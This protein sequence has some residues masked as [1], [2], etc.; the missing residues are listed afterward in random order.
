MSDLIHTADE[1]VQ[2]A[3]DAISAAHHL[4]AF[5]GAG[6]SAESGI[7]TFRG[8]SGIW[9][10]YDPLVLD[11]GF[12]KQNPA[13]SWRAIRD[14][15]YKKAAE[16]PPNAGHL[17]LADW[18]KRGVLK[19][20]ITQN[21]DDLHYQAGNRSVSE[22]HGNIRN[23]VCMKT[24]KL[25]PFDPSVFQD[26][27]PVPRS[28]WGGIYKPDFVF[29][30]EGIPADAA[31][32]SAQETSQCDVML[33]IGSTGAVYPAAQLPQLAASNGATIIEINP[34][35]SAYTNTITDI[36]LQYKAAEILPLINKL[37]RIQE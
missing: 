18:E 6:M 16:N 2:K 1:T 23:L 10:E 4:V 5:T 24:G 19:H 7:P 3:A 20:I 33:V 11:I 14:I 17:I 35:S 32:R 22:Y 13:E 21:I 34:N 27:D 36:H 12:F 37:L 31:R 9:N 26:D 25:V 30:G 8:E 15:F 29:F 28:P